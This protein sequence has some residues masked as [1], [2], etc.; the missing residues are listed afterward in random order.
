[1]DVDLFEAAK[2]AG[3]THSRSGAQQVEHWARIGREFE[4]SP[5]VSLRD[6]AAVLAGRGG[7]D[8]L[9]EREQAVV[10][11]VWDE[12]IADDMAN[13]NLEEEFT[14]EGGTWV[15]GDGSGAAVLKFAPATRG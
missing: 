7:Y 10:R 3:K 4:R 8:D 13:L 1:M 2:A 11:A 14:V 12:Q 6:V 5:G 9:R 15:V